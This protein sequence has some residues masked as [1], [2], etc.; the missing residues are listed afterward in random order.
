MAPAGRA[1]GRTGRPASGGRG[2]EQLRCRH[3]G[4]RIPVERAG[5]GR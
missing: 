4:R 3:G 5:R 2:F 1:G